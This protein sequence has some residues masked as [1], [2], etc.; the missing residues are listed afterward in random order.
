MC[1]GGAPEGGAVPSEGGVQNG[2]QR[3]G[4]GRTTGGEQ[5]QTEVPTRRMTPRGRRI[6]S[7]FFIW[8]AENMLME[9][10]EGFKKVPGGP[11]IH[12]GRV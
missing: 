4:M 12:S 9:G 2:A 3:T 6:L 8:G 11:T 1:P 5:R 10:R 7:C